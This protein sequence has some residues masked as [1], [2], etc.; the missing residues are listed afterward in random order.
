MAACE[1][2]LAEGCEVRVAAASAAAEAGHL[3]LCALLW[4]KRC[5]D[6]SSYSD[7]NF[8]AKPTD[9]DIVRVAE[10]ACLGGHA[11]VLEWLEQEAGLYEE[12]GRRGREYRRQEINVGLAAAAARGGHVSLMRRQ[13]DKL[14]MAGPTGVRNW[15]PRLLCDVALGCPLPVFRDL[16][17]QWLQLEPPQQPGVPTAAGGAGG[18]LLLHALGSRTPDWREKVAL[19]LARRPDSLAA[20]LVVQD[21]WALLLRKNLFML[22]AA[23]PDFEQRLR[24]L[25]SEK[26]AR[27]PEAA[28]VAAAGVGDVGGL[29]F[30]LDECGMRLSDYCIR[31]A[32]ACGQLAVLEFLRG[33]GQL[34][35]WS[36]S[37]R[38]LDTSAAP[39]CVLAATALTM[40]CP[41]S[42]EEVHEAPRF[43]PRV[44]EG[45]AGRGDD[46]AVLRYLHEQLG[47]E[48][49]LRPIAEA[50]SVEQLEWALGVA[51]GGAGAAAG[52]AES[53]GLVFA[54]LAAGNLAAASHLHARGLTPV[55]P[56]VGQVV[57]RLCQ[58][59]QIA[60]DRDVGSFVAVRWLLEQRLAGRAAASNWVGAG[61]AAAVAAGAWAVGGAAAV[62]RATAVGDAA[63][64]G[65]GAGEAAM[66]LADAEWDCLLTEVGVDGRLR[67]RFSTGQWEWLRAAFLASPVLPHDATAVPTGDGFYS[68]SPAI[69]GAVTDMLNK[70]KQ[71]SAGQASAG[72]AGSGHKAEV[73]AEARAEREREWVKDV[74]AAR[75][76]VVADVERRFWEW[77]A[78]Y[79]DRDH[80]ADVDDDDD[81]DDDDDEDEDED[82]DDEGDD[83]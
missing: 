59:V 34:P 9:A 16:A 42:Q 13:L 48:V 56:S 71:A 78:Y 19:V 24:Y 82:E 68:C 50:G 65:G 67:G 7:S 53:Q 41:T 63:A 74:I 61:G 5:R 44:F 40:T 70:R 69:K 37:G 33:R 72:D 52:K 4:S 39:V 25:V 51:A 76:L 81:D 1:R 28:L 21:R 11:H 23:Q 57:S 43:W 49:Q 12:A 58:R 64:V 60:P 18:A 47:A 27:A 2:L 80:D 10:A 46:V 36:R 38:A 83:D 15:A 31:E 75:R 29:R 35:S 17:D 32:A 8:F 26:G 3:C 14:V 20:G 54:A 45:A 79:N 30:L 6:Y 77:V 22:A 66:G 55:L 62:A 73:E